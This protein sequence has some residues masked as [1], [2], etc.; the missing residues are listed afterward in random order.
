MRKGGKRSLWDPKERLVY[1]RNSL[2]GRKNRSFPIG[3]V[4]GKAAGVVLPIELYLYLSTG[5]VGILHRV[6]EIH[7]GWSG[8]LGSIQLMWQLVELI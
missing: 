4:C 5:N 3:K 6:F 8:A 2:A 1:V 7:P